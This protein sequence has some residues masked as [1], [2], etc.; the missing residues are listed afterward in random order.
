MSPCIYLFTHLFISAWTRGYLLYSLGYNPT[1]SLF[2]LLFKLFWLW[3]LL[4]WLL[5]SLDTGPH[6]G[7]GGLFFV[8]WVFLGLFLVFEALPCFLALQDALSSSG[9]FHTPAPTSAIA[10]QGPGEVLNKYR[11]PVCTRGR[12]WGWGLHLRLRNLI[13]KKLLMIRC[14]AGSDDISSGP[15]T[16][17]TGS[18]RLGG[19]AQGVKRWGDPAGIWFPESALGL[20]GLSVGERK[21][22]QGVHSPLPTPG[23]RAHGGTR[24][25]GSLR[26]AQHRQPRGDSPQCNAVSGTSHTRPVARE[27]ESQADPVPA[28]KGFGRQR[29]SQEEETLC[30]QTGKHADLPAHC[31]S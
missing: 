15:P 31:W 9:I 24:L 28:A 12:G 6:P 3:K 21:T 8:F 10:P 22:E 13:R 1:L 25:G 18:L 29:Q 16:S 17:P 11:P 23:P 7:L 4:G 14:P 27:S 19:P 20:R 2:I 26:W 5:R 30:V